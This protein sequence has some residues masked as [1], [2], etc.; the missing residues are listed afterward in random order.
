[1]KLFSTLF[2]PKTKEVGSSVKDCPS[3]STNS[4]R[5]ESRSSS[6]KS[7]KLSSKK[8]HKSSKKQPPSVIATDINPQIEIAKAWMES[9]N[10]RKNDEMLAA[11]MSPKCKVYLEDGFN[12]T[13]QTFCDEMG[14]I[15][16]S[17]PDFKFT[18]ESVCTEGTNT[19]VI[20]GMY[21][22]GTHTGAPYS[23]D[24]RK[25]PEIPATNKHIVN[26]EERF[27]FKFT[28][29]NKLKSFQVVAIG[30]M[31][32]PAGLYEQVGGSI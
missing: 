25:F 24:P 4:S 23:C 31:T 15:Y 27:V 3:Q 13:A 16:Q 26:E 7:S 5:S 29:D 19:V 14:R 12:T 10:K 2:A 11:F 22:S 32:G 1:M 9:S 17:F 18:Y 20:N 21:A 8:S 28:D 6:K 30:G